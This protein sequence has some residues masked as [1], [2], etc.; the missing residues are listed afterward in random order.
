[1]RDEDL[2]KLVY[3]AIKH[4]W[5]QLEAG[6]NPNKLVAEYEAWE[7]QRHIDSIEEEEIE[8]QSISIE[9]VLTGDGKMI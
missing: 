3:K 9:R 1:M 2:E 7:I 8:Q 4:I 6:L 5:E